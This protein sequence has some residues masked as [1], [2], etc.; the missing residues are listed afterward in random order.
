MHSSTSS[1]RDGRQD[2]RCCLALSTHWN[3]KTKIKTYYT[4]GNS[5]SNKLK[6]GL[7]RTYGSGRPLSHFCPFAMEELPSPYRILVF[8]KL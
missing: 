1:A 4:Q 7:F 2:L 3:N 6:V 5:V 8:I